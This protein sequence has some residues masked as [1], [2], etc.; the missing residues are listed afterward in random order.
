MR[1]NRTPAL[2]SASAF[3]GLSLVL[4]GCNTLGQNVTDQ[5]DCPA[6]EGIG[7]AS[8][9]TIRDIISRPG[10]G[11]SATLVAAASNSDPGLDDSPL[12]RSDKIIKVVV[13]PFVDS[14]GIYHEESTVYAVVERGGWELER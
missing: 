8:I 12:Y 7:C 1:T 2:V 5:W 14:A 4:S 10:H 3:M 11:H 6:E 13:S 9:D